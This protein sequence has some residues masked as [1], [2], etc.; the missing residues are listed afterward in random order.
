MSSRPLTPTMRRVLAFIASYRSGD[1]AGEVNGYAGQP[2]LNLAAMYGLE[3]RGLLEYV[4]PCDNCAAL[5]A[6]DSTATRETHPCLRPIGP[7]G[8]YR[9]MR[10]TDAGRAVVA[11]INSAT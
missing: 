9:R 10:I 6:Y 2:G 8:C 7:G 1:I 5:G 4:A 11:E 3:S